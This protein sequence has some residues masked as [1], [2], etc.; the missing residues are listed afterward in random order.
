MTPHTQAS[1]TEPAMTVE[2]V[3]PPTLRMP[4][5]NVFGWFIAVA[6]A[7]PYVFPNQRLNVRITKWIYDCYTTASKWWSTR[8]ISKSR[9]RQRSI[10]SRTF[11]IWSNWTRRRCCIACVSASPAIWYTRRRAP[12][13]SLSIQWHRY[14]STRKRYVCVRIN[15]H[16]MNV[17]R[18]T[19][20]Y[21]CGLAA[22]VYTICGYSQLELVLTSRSAVVA[23]SVRD[24][25]FLLLQ[26][27]YLLS[28]L[29]IS[30]WIIFFVYCFYCCRF[31]H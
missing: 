6:S 15:W 1:A 4:M 31:S 3:M 18:L 22:L 30:K 5:V 13:C 27:Y 14:R 16:H 21:A 29:H 20:C 25:K 11:A 17:Q 7:L 23:V 28:I 9:I 2:M 10:W 24:N 19:I 26:F 8:M 12:R